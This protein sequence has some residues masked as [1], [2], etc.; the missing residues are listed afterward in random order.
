[1]DLSADLPWFCIRYCIRYTASVHSVCSLQQEGLQ[2]RLGCHPLCLLLL[3]LCA[4]LICQPGGQL[5]LLCCFLGICE[6][7]SLLSASN[8][9]WHAHTVTHSRR[10]RQKQQSSILHAPATTADSSCVQGCEP[11]GGHGAISMTN[12]LCCT[13]LLLLR[14]PAGQSPTRSLSASCAALSSL[15]LRATSRASCFL[16]ASAASHSLSWACRTRHKS[17]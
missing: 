9:E 8:N 5:P 3:R 15:S 7:L 6:P 10:D 14:S 4:R 16:W 17:S 1:M 2:C 13:A 12:R 11:P